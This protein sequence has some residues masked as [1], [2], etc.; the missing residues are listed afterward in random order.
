VNYLRRTAGVALLWACLA[1]L[2]A[3]GASADVG[4]PGAGFVDGIS[5][6]SLPAWDG[7]FPA[8]PFA[9][10][11]AHEL[12]GGGPRQITMARYVVQWDAASEPSE[13][14]NP[15]GDYR[16]R[17]EAWVGDVASVGLTPVL[18]LT[19]YDGRQPPGAAEYTE[20]LRALLALAAA[21][22]API[23]WVEAWNEPNDQGREPAAAAAG[24]ANAANSVCASEAHCT[25]IAGDLQD[26]PAA[27]AYEHEYELGLDFTP[28]VWGVHPYVAVRDHND[29]NLLA[30]LS[31]P[32]EGG[33]GAQLWFTEV[34]AYY[35]E[36]GTARGEARQAADAE[37][38]ERL[39]EDPALAPT[40]VFY[41][42]LLYKDGEPAPCNG[43]SG[44]SDTELFG[45]EGRP[46]QAAEVLLRGMGG[47][48][49][50]LF[51]PVP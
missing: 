6:Q 23:P 50:F 18:A 21:D 7:S 45:P 27:P 35:C 28:R 12:L 44:D 22:G 9:A 40:H 1:A 5:D 3:P 48:R 41:Y 42:G 36:A 34:G 33:A 8:S 51:G 15:A 39:I 14:P 47:A 31:A 13:G 38:L 43:G 32:P 25:V 2:S 29:A 24:L 20:Q 16:E 26:T 30:M 46:R 17:L 19:S 11:L 10:F 37:Y 49:S 4:A